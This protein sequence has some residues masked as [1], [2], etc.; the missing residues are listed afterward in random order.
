VALIDPRE[1]EGERNCRNK[2]IDFFFPDERFPISLE[3]FE[4]CDTCECRNL[5]AEYAIQN[6]EPYGVWGGIT[7]S[8]RRKIA[9]VRDQIRRK[10]PISKEIPS[11]RT[12]HGPSDSGYRVH[13]TIGEVPCDGC[14]ASH[15][16]V[17]RLYR[18]RQ[19]KKK[20]STT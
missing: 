12:P 3:V 7:Q 13:I 19:E 11:C 5:C 20:Q 15:R 6:E 10:Y 2:P 9:W 1:W 4:L 14:V 17:Q 8:E 18:R 16:E